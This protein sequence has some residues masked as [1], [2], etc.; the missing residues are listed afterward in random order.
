M[1]FRTTKAFD[2]FFAGLG[3]EAKARA[4]A[5]LEAEIR[6]VRSLPP[7]PERAREVHRKVDECQGRFAANHPEIA[8]QVRCGPGCFH[9]CRIWVGATGDE[10]ALLAERV[11]AGTARPDLGR[12]RAQR[13]WVSPADFIGKPWEE[14]ACVFL[15]PAGECTVHQDRPSICRA[16]LVTSDPKACRLGDLASSIT[17]VIDPHLEAVVSAALTVDDEDAQGSGGRH[18]S[19]ELARRLGEP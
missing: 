18:L 2:A 10:A 4:L 3:P 6:W 11:R 16:V 7:G 19:A 12:M 9:C 5:I 13:D 14:A 17:A 8:A 15:G 1:T